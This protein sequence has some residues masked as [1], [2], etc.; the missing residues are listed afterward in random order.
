MWRPVVY[1]GRKRLDISKL[2]LIHLIQTPDPTPALITKVKRLSAFVMCYVFSCR[3]KTCSVRLRLQYV[4]RISSE[5]D[6]W[7]DE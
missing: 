7:L 2:E 5:I 4:Y 6:V 3:Y 1:V